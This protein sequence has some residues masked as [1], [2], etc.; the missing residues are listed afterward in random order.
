MERCLRLFGLGP[1][2]LRR[3]LSLVTPNRQGLL[4]F[5]RDS[6]PGLLQFVKRRHFL[7]VII[8][9]A[10]VLLLR[11]ELGPFCNL[12]P[13]PLD[14]SRE[15]FSSF[16]PMNFFFGVESDDLF[17]PLGFLSRGVILEYFS[18]LEYGP[19]SV[20]PP[21]LEPAICVG[22][23]GAPVFNARALPY[24]ALILIY[25]PFWFTLFP[26]IPPLRARG[27]RNFQPP[28]LPRTP[29]PPVFSIV[30]WY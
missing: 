23:S 10:Q 17:E 9:C 20:L 27:G 30:S 29:P 11:F 8:H 19:S 28:F 13:F 6:R 3:S 18:I 26:L 4:I 24:L 25:G 12:F 7:S 15:Y 1:F 2:V 14:A 5:S 22:N 16:Y 21:L